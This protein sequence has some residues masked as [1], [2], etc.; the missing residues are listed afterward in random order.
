MANAHAIA[1]ASPQNRDASGTTATAEDGTLYTR[2]TENQAFDCTLTLAHMLRTAEEAHRYEWDAVTDDLSRLGIK[3]GPSETCTY[4]A[5]AV[6]KITKGKLKPLDGMGQTL[7]PPDSTYTILSM[8]T[9][10]SG[11]GRTTILEQKKGAVEGERLSREEVKALLSSGNFIG[12]RGEI[13]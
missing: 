13:Q 5:A 12:G 1:D 6:V 3:L 7:E 8:V 11:L 2:L 9:R 4:Y 10:G